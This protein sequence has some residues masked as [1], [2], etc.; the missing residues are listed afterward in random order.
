MAQWHYYGQ[1]LLVRLQNLV[2]IYVC[3]YIYFHIQVNTHETH[4]QLGY[5][6]VYSA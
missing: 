4:L 1:K 6:S 3:K 5:Q 2:G